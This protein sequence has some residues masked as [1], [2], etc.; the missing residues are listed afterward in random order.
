MTTQ[1]KREQSQLSN[2]REWIES[3][4]G[5]RS[6]YIARYGSVEDKHCGDGGEAI[7]AADHAALQ[8]LWS[9]LNITLQTL[10]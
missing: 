8:R 9:E 5:C 10:D 3:R 4:G 2:Q 6:G 1:R 7:W